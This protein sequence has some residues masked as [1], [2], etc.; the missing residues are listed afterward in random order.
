MSK[1]TFTKGA[2]STTT[3]PSNGKRPKA[4]TDRRVHYHK[5]STTKSTSK[6][7]ATTTSTKL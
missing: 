1:T 2:K 3:N 5:T 4:K 6:P 7:A